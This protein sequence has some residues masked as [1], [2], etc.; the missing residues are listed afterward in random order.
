MN[1]YK[2][3]GMYARHDNLQ[4]LILCMVVHDYGIIII[5]GSV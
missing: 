4:K 3:Y 1:L 2:W 5:K